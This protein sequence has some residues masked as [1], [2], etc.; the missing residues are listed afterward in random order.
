MWAENDDN[1][2][3]RKN[4]RWEIEHMQ[5]SERAA[6]GR[7][8]GVGWSRNQASPTWAS[9]SQTAR[10]T[11]GPSM[12]T[13]AEERIKCCNRGEL[14]GMKNI[15]FKFSKS[16]VL[17]AFSCRK[18][19]QLCLLMTGVRVG[20]E[21]YWLTTSQSNFIFWAQIPTFLPRKRQNNLN[22]KTSKKNKP[23]FY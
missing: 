6:Q 10:E 7:R 17:R 1:F 8:G 16:W 15:R 2:D 22:H 13:D 19:L 12:G 4:I 9:L 3:R 23:L 5:E 20:C 21:L 14:E 11:T 18:S